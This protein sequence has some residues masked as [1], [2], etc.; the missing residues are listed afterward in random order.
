MIAYRSAGQTTVSRVT[1]GPV[2]WWDD[3][4]GQDLCTLAGLPASPAIDQTTL[5]VP[6]STSRQ[7]RLYVCALPLG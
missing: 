2:P 7:T 6:I 3:L 5:Y 1:I 4:P